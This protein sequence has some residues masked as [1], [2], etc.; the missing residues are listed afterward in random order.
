MLAAEHQYRSADRNQGM[1][2]HDDTRVI[3]PL[4]Y[5]GVLLALG[6]YFVATERKRGNSWR[7]TAERTLLTVLPTCLVGL[8]LAFPNLRQVV[9]VAFVV[10]IAGSL[11]MI[12]FKRRQ[13]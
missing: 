9:K 8:N 4:V 13:Q 5:F 3:H 1:G 12:V 2:P 11:V 10:S 7:A 6:A